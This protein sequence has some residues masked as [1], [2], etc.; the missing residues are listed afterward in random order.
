V[1]LRSA[2]EVKDDL[3]K[4]AVLYAAGAVIAVGCFI[5]AATLGNHS[6]SDSSSQGG[7][8]AGAS[9]E[10]FMPKP[11]RHEVQHHNEVSPACQV[12]REELREE[13]LPHPPGHGAY[14]AE[15]KELVQAECGAAAHVRW[16]EIKHEETS[17]GRA[18]KAQEERGLDEHPPQ[19]EVEE[20]KHIVELEGR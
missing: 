1:K 5:L 2:A 4:H 18:E 15:D 17:A 14:L 8:G 20:A 3:R 13:E 10:Q 9:V 19:S 7:S 6:S 16:T 11:R 12:V